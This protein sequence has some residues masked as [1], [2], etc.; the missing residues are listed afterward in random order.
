MPPLLDLVH[1]SKLHW[2]TVPRYAVIG[3]PLVLA[4]ALQLAGFGMATLVPLSV[5]ALSFARL[6]WLKRLP[7][8]SARLAAAEQALAAAQPDQA[9]ALL[10]RPLP[11]AGM[12]YQVGRAAL[13]AHAFVRNGQFIEAHRALSAFN[14][15]HLQP[16]ER[17]RLRCAWSW[18][19]LQA[20]NLAEAQRQLENLP[21][22]ERAADLGYLLLKAEIELGQDRFTQARALLQTGLDR[23]HEAKHRMH[24]LNNLARL[25]GLQGRFDAQL[26]SLQAARTEFRKAPSTDLTDAI[27]HNLS[28]ALVR[29]GQLDE[30]REVLREAWAAGDATDLH[31]A[32]T[33]LNNAL[34]AAREAGDAGWTREVHDEFERQ[35][36]RLPPGTP[37]E[38]LALDVTRLRARRNDGILLKTGDYPSLIRHLLDS[39][40]APQPAI[41][42]SDRVA[43]LV[44]IRHDL[45]REMETARHPAEIARLHALLQRAA[46]QLCDRRPTID[47]HLSTLSPKLIGPLDMWHRYRTDAD[48]AQVELADSPAAQHDALARLF[49]HLREK[50]EW[51]DEQGTARQAVESWLIVCDEYVALHTQI[52]A[53]EQA[54]WRQ[55][56]LGLAQH[57]LDQ[58][59][60]RL[61][62]SKKHIQHIDHMIGLA[63]FNLQLRQDGPAA[64]RW[65]EIIEAH[66]PSLA[67]YAGWLRGQYVD[68]CAVLESHS[69]SQRAVQP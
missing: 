32:I 3:L 1:P 43:A 8:E 5:S 56:Y 67:H 29:A 10:Q 25:E 9:I 4:G 63:Y 41:P 37:R 12:N 30:A 40:D 16:D 58:A 13:L 19:F 36:T 50:A 61:E 49:C 64:R 21:E 46:R 33:V 54:T 17:L 15:Q 59:T 28:I 11:F 7:H 44:E 48:K 14:E 31:H 62:G 69:R 65:V 68:V 42:E 26:R 45:K 47:A 53:T 27:H 35:L 39:L 18:L 57:A 55:R 60:A 24:L 38:R 22:S 20:E 23:A 66:K 6:V 51:L 2:L 52:P 34:H